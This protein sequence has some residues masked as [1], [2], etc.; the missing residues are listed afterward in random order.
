MDFKLIIISPTQTH[1]ATAGNRVRILNFVERLKK[2]YDVDIY[3]LYVD[4]DGEVTPDTIDYWGDRLNVY[5]SLKDMSSPKTRTLVDRIKLRMGLISY[6]KWDY[7]FH[8][9]ECFDDGILA[10][11]RDLFAKFNFEI[12]LTE[13]VFMTKAFQAFPS[14][15]KKILDTHDRFSNRFE[16]YPVVNGRRPYRWFSTYP[17]DEKKALNRADAIIAI[18]DEEAKSF[19]KMT[20]RKVVTVGHLFDDSFA[21]ETT[22]FKGESVLFFAS[23]NVINVD[24]Y[25][26]FTQEVWPLV[27]KQL[28]TC[29][30]VVAGRICRVIEPV[31][32]IVFLGEVTDKLE[33]YECASISINPMLYGSGLK[34]KTLESL[35]MGIPV[36]S[37]AHGAIGLEEM[38]DQS[39]FVASDAA[40]FCDNIVNL[41]TDKRFYSQVE[42]SLRSCLIDYQQRNNEV[43]LDLFNPIV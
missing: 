40:T 25:H 27:V 12:V 35:T 32:G 21:E 26:F 23:D 36:V 3:F 14:K 13:Y 8:I 6:E 4:L 7:N 38:I 19:R 37:T 9:D 28:P 10:V 41:L 43:I 29:K 39:I 33:A 30:F 18:Q 15:V 20:N 24:A 16:I 34:I 31:D 17:E 22:H 5:H 1:P 42:Q 11:C 2:L